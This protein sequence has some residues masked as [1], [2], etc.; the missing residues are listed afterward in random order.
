MV[1]LEKWMN[2][3]NFRISEGSEYTEAIFGGPLFCLDSWDR[4][5]IN[6]STTIVINTRTQQI[7]QV[8]VCDYQNN[9]AYRLLNE[10]FRAPSVEIDRTAWDDIEYVDLES[11]DDFIEKMTAILNNEPYDTR[12]SI[13]IT[14]EDDELFN[15]MMIA[16]SMD[17]TFNQLVEHALAQAIES[18]TTT[19]K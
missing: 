3:V 10:A 13:P 4:H 1:T 15:L 5:P 12:V 16:H 11:D 6:S 7:C 14:L 17:L 8:T 9:R 2:I 19:V 18:Y